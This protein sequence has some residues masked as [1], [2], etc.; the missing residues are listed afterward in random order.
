[1][2]TTPLPPRIAVVALDSAIDPTS[3]LLVRL[4]LAEL[5][6]ITRHQDLLVT[7]TKD[8]N[9]TF[10]EGMPQRWSHNDYREMA[11]L[12]QASVV[13]DVDVLEREPEVTA[14]AVAHYLSRAAPDTLPTF[15]GRTDTAVARSLARHLV[16]KTLPRAER[17][18]DA[19]QRERQ[20]RGCVSS[21]QPYF[22]F[23][24]DHVASFIADDA[25]HPR[26]VSLPPRAA[27]SA[28]PTFLAQFVVDSSGT[29]SPGTLKFLVVPSAAAADSAK[30]AILQWRFKPAILTGCKVAQL[31]QVELE[32]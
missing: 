14:R 18:L 26:P 1:M 16:T 6:R 21:D 29:P 24:V 30:A 25:V 31:V 12:V 3:P 2:R 11:K 4:V 10:D 5:D 13:V 19:Y 7:S 22:E 9:S 8:V 20:R 23:Q 28:R 32:R 27:G 15:H 17:E